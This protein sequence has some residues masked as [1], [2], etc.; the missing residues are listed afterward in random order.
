MIQ[1][2]Q[3]G[4][5]SELK[6]FVRFPH[7]LFKGNEFWV[8]PL[9]RD[10]LFTF[11]KEKNPAFEHCTAAYWLAYKEGK[12]VGRIAGIINHKANEKWGKKVRFGWIDFIEDIEVA[13]VLLDTVEAWGRQ[14]GMESIQGPLGF[15]D[16]DNEGMLVEGFD[17]L[18]TIANIYNYPYYPVFMEKLG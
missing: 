16:M 2:K 17:K 13:K 3:V 18:P 1:I 7:Q 10:E 9:D 14:N 15:N 6:A 11:S 8:P 4:T 12:V 5:K